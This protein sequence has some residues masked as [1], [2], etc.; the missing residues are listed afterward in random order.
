V[1]WAD[2][3]DAPPSIALLQRSLERGRLGHAYLFSGDASDLLERVAGELA[4]TVNCTRPPSVSPGGI[5]TAA[6][7]TCSSCRRIREGLHPDVHWLRPES[8]SRILRVEQVR[9]LIGA[10]QLKPTEARYKVGVLVG[11]DRLHPTAANA[12]LKT[13]EEPPA[14]SLLVLL[15]TEPDRLLETIL[16]RC[17]RLSFPGEPVADARQGEWLRSVATEL[18]TAPKSLLYRYRL[19][20]RLLQHLAA[21]RAAAEEEIETRSPARQF[22]DADPALLEQWEEEA[23][24]AL[25]AEYR[26]RRGQALRMLQGWLRDVWLLALGQPTSLLLFPELSAESRAVA[27]RLDAPRA[28]ANLQLIESTQTLLHTNVQEALALEVAFLRLEL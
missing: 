28:L 18:R 4:A 23:K 11:A 1:A 19:L 6:C 14:G 24:A 3:T 13:L 10:V 12:F 25:E 17:L 21:M 9:D 16:S 8:K 7:G 20:D 2:F 27:G 5:P 15:S 22:R 26:Q